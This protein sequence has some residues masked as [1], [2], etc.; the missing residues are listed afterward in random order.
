[1]EQTKYVEKNRAMRRHLLL[2]KELEQ[3]LPALYAT[4]GDKTARAI[5]KFFSPYSNWTWYAFEYDPEDGIFY[6][7]VKGFDDEWGNFSL[8]E[9]DE[10]MFKG[11]PAVERDCYIDGD[12]LPTKAD[13]GL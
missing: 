1:M 6:G 12:K 3:K 10:T 4:D 7:F 9:L 5:V 2:P 13:L 8:Q 11:V